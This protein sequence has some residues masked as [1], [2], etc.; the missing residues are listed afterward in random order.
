MIHGAVDPVVVWQNSLEFMKEC[1]KKD[2]QVDYF[3]YP[4]HE[5]NVRGKDRIHLM[6]KVTDYF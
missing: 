5:H 2:K 4:D 1:V 6:Q 3:V